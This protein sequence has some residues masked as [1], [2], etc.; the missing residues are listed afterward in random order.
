MDNNKPSGG[1]NRDERPKGNKKRKE[2]STFWKLILGFLA[3]LVIIVLIIWVP[4]IGQPQVLWKDD[5]STN[6]SHWGINSTNRQFLKSPKALPENYQGKDTFLINSGDEE[7]T[8]CKNIPKDTNEPF[9]V[10]VTVIPEINPSSKTKFNQK[11]DSSKDSF[12]LVIRDYKSQDDVPDNPLEF[13]YGK[14]YKL[15]LVK[16]NGSNISR[17]DKSPYKIEVKSHKP[18]RL[19]IEFDTTSVN[20][21][22]NG[23]L[24]RGENDSGNFQSS[25]SFLGGGEINN[26]CIGFF[27]SPNQILYFYDF[28][29][30][31]Y[32]PN[33]LQQQ[34]RNAIN[35]KDNQ[36]KDLESK[37]NNLA[38]KLDGNYPYIDPNSLLFKKLINTELVANYKPID[39]NEPVS[40]RLLIIESKLEGKKTPPKNVITKPVVES[41]SDLQGQYTTLL[42]QYTALSGQYSALSGQ[43]SALKAEISRIPK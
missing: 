6:K 39:S 1:F 15:D 7:W 27:T 28:F 26:K 43:Y 19:K 29:A 34:L 32:V 8:K 40:K 3:V 14:F 37:I 11:I 12:G 21:Y 20:F 33:D 4:S 42:G 30:E 25:F 38:A 17:D 22:I 13:K 35:V 24:V 9:F 16:S 18:Y 41:L 36:I 2:L 5:F 31:T 10:S 23:T